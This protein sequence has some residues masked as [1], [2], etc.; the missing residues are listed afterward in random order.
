MKTVDSRKNLTNDC[1]SEGCVLACRKAI[2]EKIEYYLVVKHFNKWNL[3]DL[4]SCQLQ[5]ECGF[6]SSVELEKN[7]ST[8]VVE[9]QIVNKD[10]VEI[11][12]SG[13]KK[14]LK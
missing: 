5:Y 7:I 3:V 14:D 8:G 10:N 9:I 13:L 4:H 1:L 2:E 12:F 6:S 11:F